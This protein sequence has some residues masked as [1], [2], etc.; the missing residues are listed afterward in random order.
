MN[1]LIQTVALTVAI[2]SPSLIGLIASASAHHSASHV[3]TIAA[4]PTT[5]K[6]GKPKAK[7]AKKPMTT[8]NS[9]K[10]PGAM[11]AT[12][13]TP[14]T[15]TPTGGSS[16]PT[17]GDTMKP[18]KPDSVPS[19]KAKPNSAID[20]TPKTDTNLPSV[21]VSTPGSVSAPTPTG[22]TPGMSNPSVPSVPSGLPK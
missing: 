1:K 13:T 8:G 21:P 17:G 14:E 22:N 19:T 2:F 7:K 4:D 10:K 11:D 5:T 3:T 15:S 16:T 9:N 18:T 12:T 20:T 6:P